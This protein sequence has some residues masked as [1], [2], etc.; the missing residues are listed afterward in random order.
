MKCVVASRAWWKLT[1]RRESAMNFAVT[2][3]ACEPFAAPVSGS[4]EFPVTQLPSN[5]ST[6]P[7]R[8]SL[9]PFPRPVRLRPPPVRPPNR[10]GP[11]EK[12]KLFV[13]SGRDLFA[14]TSTFIEKTQRNQIQVRQG[15]RENIR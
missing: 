4:F 8:K 2:L 13:L 3:A 14:S 1:F 15:C 12:R 10:H 5:D 7:G 11:F 9:S 6:N